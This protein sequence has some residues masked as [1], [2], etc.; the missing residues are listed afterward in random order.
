M[1]DA[2]IELGYGT[3]IV[4]S[5]G[6]ATGASPDSAALLG[7]TRAQLLEPSFFQTL[8]SAEQHALLASD[9]FSFTLKRADHAGDL[10]LLDVRGRKTNGGSVLHISGQPGFSVHQDAGV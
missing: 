7:V 8:L 3:C 6:A 10:Q 9:D 2:A 4:S 1:L 5:S